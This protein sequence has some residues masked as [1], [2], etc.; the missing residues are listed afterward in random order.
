M[1]QFGQQFAIGEG[2]LVSA[3]EFSSPTFQKAI[4]SNQLL[5]QLGRLSLLV[6]HVS[7]EFL[8]TGTK[9]MGLY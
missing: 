5:Q 9:E 8:T 1:L 2:H 7:A 3:E 4:E 6:L